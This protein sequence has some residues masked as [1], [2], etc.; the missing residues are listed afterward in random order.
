M[1][2]VSVKP[3]KLILCCVKQCKCKPKYIYIILCGSIK[4]CKC[5]KYTYL[6][7]F[8]WLCKKCDFYLRRGDVIMF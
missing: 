8:T 5:K 6:Y 3:C 1:K 4:K 7:D 2:C